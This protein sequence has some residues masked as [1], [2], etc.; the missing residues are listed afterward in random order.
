MHHI[1]CYEKIALVCE[2]KWHSLILRLIRPFIKTEI[3]FF[4]L[5]E[6]DKALC[7]IKN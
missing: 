5:D 7:W 1:G 2:K 4:E 6:K 3:N